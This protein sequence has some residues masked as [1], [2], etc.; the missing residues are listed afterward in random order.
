[1]TGSRWKKWDKKR[2]FRLLFSTKGVCSSAESDPG[3]SHTLLWFLN[4]TDGL[5]AAPV[6]EPPSLFFIF[7]FSFPYQLF[8]IFIQ[9]FILR[10]VLG[11]LS[12]TLSTVYLCGKYNTSLQQGNTDK[13]VKMEPLIGNTVIKRGLPKLITT[14]STTSSS[15]TVSIT[16]SIH[17][18]KNTSSASGL[19]ASSP[20]SI[21]L[22]DSSSFLS[23]SASATP[24]PTIIPPS[25]EGNPYI[26]KM[27]NLPPNGTVFIAVGACV[28][29]I[30]LA[31]LVWWALSLYISSKNAKHGGQLYYP[32]DTS[33]NGFSQEGRGH[34]HQNSL[35]SQATHSTFSDSSS[36]YADLDEEKL[37][38]LEKE[39][40]R[41]SLFG[42]THTLTGGD[43]LAEDAMT[44]NYNDPEVQ[45]FNAIQ[46]GTLGDNNRRSLF[47]S[48]TLEVFQQ[49]NTPQRTSRFSEFQYM[50][51]DG[52]VSNMSIDS[53]FM[54]SNLDSPSRA[55][56]PERK[57]KVREESHYESRNQSAIG[58]VGTGSLPPSPIKSGNP[59]HKKSPSMFLDD[60]L[61]D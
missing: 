18:S 32:K 16:S 43:N 2:S 20:S 8:K 19:V 28:G 50:M 45:M 48:P 7:F 21:S 5:V 14:T 52:N 59:Y 27:T 33:A 15:S 61:E 26:A 22:L 38:P 56:S 42:L 6:Y 17:D 12:F 44:I 49:Q 41:R 54:N 13:F 10:S 31:I 9:L 37:I 53:S 60:M 58:L 11:E 57:K 51:N 46:D 25:P 23:S 1:M 47:V 29:A 30:F 36:R 24:T 4:I 3:R 35:M 55:A 34:K 40:T 39:Q